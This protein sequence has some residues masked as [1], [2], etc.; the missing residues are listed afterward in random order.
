[1][2]ALSRVLVAAIYGC[3]RPHFVPVAAVYGR[4][5]SPFITPHTP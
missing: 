2:A 5:M 1:M 3:P 4:P